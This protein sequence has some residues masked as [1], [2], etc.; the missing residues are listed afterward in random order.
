[1]LWVLALLLIVI[2]LVGTL[3]PGLPG[4]VAVFGG[5][6]LA[7]WADGFVQIGPGTLGVLALLTIA[8][9][10][11]DIMGVA[12]GVRRSGASGRATAGAAL[13]A[14]VGLFFGV[15]GLL[16]GPFLGAIVAELTVRQDLRGAGRAGIAA[17][18]GIIVGTVAKLAVVVA[19]VGIGVA[20]FL[21]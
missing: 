8:A 9:H 19:M 13:G 18:I 14:L 10:I 16:I 1:M 2:G 15:P 12:L 20:A 3:L 4:P 7:A 21:W 5:L 17:W 6:L 11:V